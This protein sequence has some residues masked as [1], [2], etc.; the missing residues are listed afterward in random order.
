MSNIFLYQ[1][2]VRDPKTSCQFAVGHI[3]S[4]KHDHNTI[5]YWLSEWLRSKV[6]PPQ[7]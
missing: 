5:S 6:P 7:K 4:E 2:G 1:I 3:L